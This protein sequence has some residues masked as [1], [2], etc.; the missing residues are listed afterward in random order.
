MHKF[1]FSTFLT[2]ILILASCSG[3]KNLTQTEQSGQ[4]AY[5]AGDYQKALSEWEI[6]I[7]EYKSKGIENECPVYFEAAEAAVK[8]GQNEKAIDY[9]KADLNTTF[10][11]GETYFNLAELY[12][13]IDNLSKEM[14]MLNAYLVKYPAGE[15]IDTVRT[16]LFEIEAE[17]KDWDAVVNSWNNLSPE[18]QSQIPMIET[19]FVANEK[20]DNDSVCDQL[21]MQL[22]E[23]DSKNTVALEWMAKKLF[24]QAEKRYQQ[25]MKDYS[26]NKTN[27]QYKQ[28]LGA[29]DIVSADFKSSLAYFTELY[30]VDPSPENAKYLGDI[31]NRLDD[32]KKADYY[33]ELA[34]K[35]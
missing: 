20:L 16:R 24:W 17:I 22:L 32:K 26:D 3:G 23:K 30:T 29:L 33:Y 12:R 35:K 28:L 2:S 8:L 9:L 4:L 6:V 27:K 34:G 14:D 31:Y 13:Q 11:S 10:A 1:L 18:V 5:N 25:E 7:G 19:Y 15:K 21:A